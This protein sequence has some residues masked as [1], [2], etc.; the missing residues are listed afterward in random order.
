M[1]SQFVDIATFSIQAVKGKQNNFNICSLYLSVCLLPCCLSLLLFPDTDG[2]SSLSPRGESSSPAQLGRWPQRGALCGTHGS[3]ERG[4][5]SQHDARR[6][7]VQQPTTH[8]L[9]PSPGRHARQ[10]AVAR[11]QPHP[12]PSPDSPPASRLTD[13]PA[14]HPQPSP[15][16]TPS[17][18]PAEP[19]WPWPGLQ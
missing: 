7:P 16:G 11:P 2:H 15:A 6:A 19:A 3:P 9:P 5:G 14:A 4:H 8:Q 10:L 12:H 1:F 17:V 18:P 13:P